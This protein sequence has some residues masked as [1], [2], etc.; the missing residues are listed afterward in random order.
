MTAKIFKKGEIDEARRR[1][2]ED[3]QDQPRGGGADLP[4][5]TGGLIDTLFEIERDHRRE[6]LDMPHAA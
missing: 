5:V 4:P 6:P 2:G 3:T 1:R